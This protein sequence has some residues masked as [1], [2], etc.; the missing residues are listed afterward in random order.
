MRKQ[1]S[2]QGFAWKLG[3]AG[4]TLAL[5]AGCGGGSSDSGSSNGDDQ[6]DGQEQA[7]AE[8][9]WRGTF[10]E[11]GE[12]FD[13]QGLFYDGR[14]LAISEEAGVIYDGEYTVTGESVDAQ[15]LAYEF[16]GVSF[17]EAVLEGTVTSSESMNLVFETELGTQGTVSLEYDTQYDRSSDTEDMLKGLWGYYEPGYEAVVDV[18][19]SGDFFAQDTEGCTYLGEARSLNPNKNLYSVGMM[20][21]SCGA[22]D[23]AYTGFAALLDE[24][25]MGEILQIVVSNPNVI[26]FRPLQSID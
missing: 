4:V 9:I 12:T 26:L 17:T 11:E 16:N 22:F 25:G 24:P 14:I 18:D 6:G 5:V 10:T 21:G 7:S 15:V 3:L 19:E 8:G 20:V 2:V 23:G 13:A 1:E